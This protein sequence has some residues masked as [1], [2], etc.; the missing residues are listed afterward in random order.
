[1]IKPSMLS[2]IFALYMCYNIFMVAPIKYVT[3]LFLFNLWIF[4]FKFWHFDIDIEILTLTLEKLKFW[5]CLF[6]CLTKWLL[7]TP[8]MDQQYRK[9]QSTKPPH[10]HPRGMYLWIKKW[11]VDR[12]G[13][14]I[15]AGVRGSSAIRHNTD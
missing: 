13:S 3:Y 4:F 5:D 11:P 6:E 12:S 14:N 8:C 10:H 15:Q 1:M 7:C 2:T 9:I